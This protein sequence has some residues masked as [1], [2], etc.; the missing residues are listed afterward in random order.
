M[1]APAN[2]VGTELASTALASAVTISSVTTAAK[3]SVSST[4]NT[5]R[6]SQRETIATAA[7]T[8]DGRESCVTF[9]AVQTTALAMASA[10]T[11]HATVK[12][13]GLVTSAICSCARASARERAR[14]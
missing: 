7:A 1:L 6:G 3:N 8:P 10:L 9:A 2:A 14:V 5:V 12:R 4:V 13:D 11:Q